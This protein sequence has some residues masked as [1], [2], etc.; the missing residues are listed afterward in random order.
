MGDDDDSM[1]AI[2]WSRHWSVILASQANKL[3]SLF[4]RLGH[5]YCAV[6]AYRQVDWSSQEL[7]Q[8]SVIASV[9]IQITTATK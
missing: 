8:Y 3:E 5:P 9:F 2:F 4:G 6:Y 7:A 1:A